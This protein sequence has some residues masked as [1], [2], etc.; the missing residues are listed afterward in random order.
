MTTTS[1]PAAHPKQ[2]FFQRTW[3]IITGTAL[4][5]LVV[6]TVIGLRGADATNSPEYEAQADKL[7]ATE[8]ELAFAKASL[9]DAEESLADTEG[10]A[11]D[12]ADRLETIEGHLDDRKAALEERRAALKKREA[13]LKK[14]VSALDQRKALLKEAVADIRERED[15]VTAAE[16]LLADTTVP[17]DGSF[18]VGV[19]VER[20]L[21]RS[22]GKTGCRYTVFGDAN[23]NDVLLD[24]TTPGSASVSLRDGTWFVT[25][26]CAEWTRQ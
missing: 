8:S 14:R 16:A 25:R 10:T 15:A 24:K 17:G 18:E 9:G 22:T 19:D 4:L 2:R 12:L 20:G 13:A 23:G 6:G 7:A 21:Y 5:A 3:V 1:P 26:G 11:T